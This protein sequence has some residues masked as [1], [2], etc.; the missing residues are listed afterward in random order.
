MYVINF[1]N[2]YHAGEGARADTA[3]DGEHNATGEEII[4][5]GTTAAGLRWMGW[6]IP[7]FQCRNATQNIIYS[8]FARTGFGFYVRISRSS[9]DIQPF[10]ALHSISLYISNSKISFSQDRRDRSSE[11][12]AIQILCSQSTIDRNKRRTQKDMDKEERC[13]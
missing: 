4:S 13:S 6:T 12:R 7:P 9:A 8:Y 10:S 11:R 1:Q 3:T 2:T 5:I